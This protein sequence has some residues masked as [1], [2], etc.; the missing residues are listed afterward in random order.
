MTAMTLP[1]SLSDDDVVQLVRRALSE[2]VPAQA[3]R[4]ARLSFDSK[5]VDLDVDSVTII[6]LVG[7]IEDTVGHVFEPH[8]VAAVRSIADIARLI[9]D[10]ANGDAVS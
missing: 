1:G 6:E 7:Y 8:D 4:F 10:G 3:E 9:R 2:L 5:V